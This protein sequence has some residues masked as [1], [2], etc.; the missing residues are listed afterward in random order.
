M[1]ILRTEDVSL[2]EL[3]KT[4]PLMTEDQFYAL[5][6]DISLNG[7]KVPVTLYRGKIVD[8]RHRFRALTELAIDTILANKLSNNLTLE[9]VEK[10]MLSS[11]VRRHQ[12]P[13]QLAIKAQRYCEKGS[14]QSDALKKTGASKSNLAHVRNIL[15]AGRLD[16]IATLE[17]GGKIDIGEGNF[18]KPS[19]SLLGIITW[20]KNKN[21]VLDMMT[22]A[23]DDAE[24]IVPVSYTKEQQLIL[25][26]VLASVRALPKQMRMVVVAN[27][28]NIKD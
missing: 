27:I 18:P 24:E 7:Q 19:D 4:H 14:L 17:A 3:S 10:E 6:E 8:G 22:N 25:D 11:E 13:T 2:H 21:V 9:E 26:A 15:K 20:L 16:I 1:D 5:K 12:T 28:Y 23:G